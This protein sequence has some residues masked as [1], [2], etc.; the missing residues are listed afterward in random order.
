M[1]LGSPSHCAGGVT[2]LGSHFGDWEHLTIRFSNGRPQKVYLSQHSGG[3]EFDYG[4]E[5][6]KL[7]NGRPTVFA[8]L[9]SHALYEEEDSYDVSWGGIP[10]ANISSDHTDH[11]SVWTPASASRRSSKMGITPPCPGSSTWV[12]GATRTRGT[13]IR[14]AASAS[15]TTARPRCS[16]GRSP[17]RRPA[18]SSDHEGACSDQGRSSSSDST[19]CATWSPSARSFTR[20]VCREIPSK[21]AASR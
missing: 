14:R 4:S 1:G 6:L 17:T 11:G 21:R 8:A 13:A 2:N 3:T 9:N 16:P 19:E 7:D 12:A 10:L 15:S 18:T 5:D 20:I